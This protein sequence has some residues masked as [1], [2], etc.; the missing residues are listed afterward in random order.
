MFQRLVALA[1]FLHLAG[2]ALA[3]Q[4]R[5]DAGAAGPSI[6]EAQDQYERAVDT[7]YDELVQAI[8]KRADLID[9]SL[10]SGKDPAGK[11]REA[12]EYELAILKGERA[13]L[14]AQGRWPTSLAV[15]ATAAARV[16][17]AKEKLLGVYELKSRAALMASDMQRDERLASGRALWAGLNLLGP[18]LDPA[19]LARRV[20]SGTAETDWRFE[21]GTITQP[22][23]AGPDGV[24]AAF[25]LQAG[26][27][28]QFVAKFTF[29]R[30]SSDGD[31]V[32]RF[33]D[34]LGFQRPIAITKATLESVAGKDAKPERACVL[35]VIVTKGFATLEVEGECVV[36]FASVDTGLG[37]DLAQIAS[38]ALAKSDKRGPLRVDSVS[39]RVLQTGEVAAARSKDTTSSSTAD[40]MP[41][42]S[43][44]DLCG[45]SMS[46][47]SAWSEQLAIVRAARKKYAA[48]TDRIARDLLRNFEDEKANYLQGL[49]IRTTEELRKANLRIET[50]RQRFLYG[51]VV[52]SLVPALLRMPLENEH[53]T[54]RKQLMRSFEQTEEVLRLQSRPEEIRW[55][56]ED[57]REFESIQDLALWLDPEALKAMVRV[58]PELHEW[59]WVGIK[60]LAPTRPG[61]DGATTPFVLAGE[62]PVEF[63]MDFTIHC[64]KLAL[65]DRFELHFGRS[66][67][68]REAIVLGSQIHALLP[69][70]ASGDFKP[71]TLRALV[72]RDRTSISLADVRLFCQSIEDVGGD[73]GT[74]KQ[75][76]EFTLRRSG[77]ATPFSLSDIGLKPIKSSTK[78]APKA[79]APVTNQTQLPFQLPSPPV[80]RAPLEKKSPP[81][82][83]KFTE[84]PPTLPPRAAAPSDRSMSWAEV[85]E[86][87]PDPAFVESLN[88]RTAMELEKM[89]WRVRDRKSG[90]E[91]VLIPPGSYSRGALGDDLE[92]SPEERPAHRVTITQPFYLGRYE[93]QEA[94][95]THVMKG[96]ALDTEQRGLP[97]TGTY[98]ALARL[99]D[100]APGLRLPTEAEWEYAC[101]AGG[102]D[103]RYAD[104][105]ECAWVWNNADGRAHVVGE[106]QANGFGLCDTLG[107][108]WEWCS[109]FYDPAAYK[110]CVGGVVDPTGPTTGT[111][112]VLRGGSFSPKETDSMCRVSS[113]I[114][115]EVDGGATNARGFR[116][117]RTP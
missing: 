105:A 39:M 108:V 64:P 31:L 93:V 48:T 46:V 71:I 74:V 3:A 69:R 68:E 115:G 56:D 52:P 60:W 2:F 33:E 8:T 54:A 19:A 10:K 16:A 62:L 25:T 65:E 78:R 102:S 96:L 35:C 55:L 7:S 18:G 57:K 23:V 22:K 59:R 106:L 66:S 82:A 50:E 98:A 20:R 111:L 9:A 41:E 67:D 14:E 58:G 38:I 32:V 83:E 92:A 72:S 107:N 75:A 24:W 101:R 110:L 87:E 85:I 116:V 77:T 30:A 79:A 29:K 61:S 13:A 63:Q 37:L 6:V 11:S 97:W 100:K 80:E 15:S 44:G 12:L 49:L 43:A 76:T 95:F 51:A 86:Q 40:A 45:G 21:A 70:G 27:P 4:S 88:W 94:E 91:M 28:A 84:A 1:L 34:A 17:S 103:P 36:N 104:I 112:R 99:F 90:I 47:T 114:G 42:A 117:A 73:A 81:A 113:R 53:A 109:D 26:L 5:P 89:P